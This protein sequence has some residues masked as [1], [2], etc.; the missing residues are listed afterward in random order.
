ML[1]LYA[2]CACPL[3]LLAARVL[4]HPAP[5][6]PAVSLCDVA[7]YPDLVI[8]ALSANTKRAIGGGRPPRRC[9]RRGAGEYVVPLQDLMQQAPIDEFTQ[10]DTEDGAG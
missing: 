5:C 2:A 10:S 1:T 7:V 3:P 9:R 8:R 6:R 4:P